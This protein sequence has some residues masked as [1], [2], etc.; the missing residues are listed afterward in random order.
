M[1]VEPPTRLA[2][3]WGDGSESAVGLETVVTWTLTPVDGG[4]LVRMEQSGFRPQHEM[5]HKR[6]GGGWPRIL[7]RLE[8]VAGGAE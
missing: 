3:R 7:E 2:Y 6:M 8:Q 4:T 1:A 5:A